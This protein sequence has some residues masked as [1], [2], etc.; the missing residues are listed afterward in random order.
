MRTQ[1][2]LRAIFPE[3]AEEKVEALCSNYW[4][5]YH[6]YHGAI[7]T[8]QH[9]ADSAR[10][11]R[12]EAFHFAHFSAFHCLY[13]AADSVNALRYGNAARAL[14]KVVGFYFWVGAARD[15]LARQVWL[16]LG[17]WKQDARTGALKRRSQ[18]HR[19]LH[20]A[21]REHGVEMWPFHDKLR[22]LAQAGH[23]TAHA[24][25]VVIADARTRGSWYFTLNDI[26]N[27]VVHESTPFLGVREGS[28]DGPHYLVRVTIPV[29]ERVRFVRSTD[30]GVPLL[31]EA[32][33]YPC[34]VDHQ[35]EYFLRKVCGLTDAVW[36]VLAGPI[37]QDGIPAP[38]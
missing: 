22:Q 24:L 4:K 7:E 1:R 2:I 15:Q 34:A 30:Q 10:R 25:L 23:A 12:Y 16:A 32:D 13:L 27:D 9:E 14:E 5:L 3:G 8:R 19:S 38:K 36:D 26:R 6:A 31:R 20:Y 17:L 21:R 35:C 29:D 28:P 37:A 18:E 11:V 33:T